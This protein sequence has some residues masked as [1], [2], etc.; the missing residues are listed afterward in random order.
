MHGAHELQSVHAMVPE[1]FSETERF[2]QGVPLP[3]MAAYNEKQP[4]AA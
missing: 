2:G 3:D 1:G 4:Y